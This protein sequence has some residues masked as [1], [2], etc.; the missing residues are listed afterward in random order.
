[1]Q[2]NKCIT[3]ADGNTGLT[4]IQLEGTSVTAYRLKLSNFTPFFLFN[5]TGKKERKDSGSRDGDHDWSG[6]GG[7]GDDDDD[8]FMYV[9]CIQSIN[10]S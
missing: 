10:Y 6:G 4:H 7:S 8:D 2:T 9:S 3:G 5:K 1:M